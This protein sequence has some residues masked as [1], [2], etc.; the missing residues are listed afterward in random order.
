MTGTNSKAEARTPTEIRHLGY[1]R[2]STY[3]Q[4]LDTQLEQFRADGCVE[5]YY[6]KV[7]GARTDR[8]EL[9]KLLKALTPG[10]VVIVTRIDRLAR[11]I[12]DLFA[13]V[14]QIVDAGGQFRS[15]AEPWTDTATGTG[16]LTIAAL[17]RLIDV[18]R[19]LI[20][21]RMM[22]GR[23]RAKARGQRF[24]PP[25][26]SPTR[27]RRKPAFA[28]PKERRSRNWRRPMMSG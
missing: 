18:E 21:T 19:D 17:G 2:V 12:F 5:I 9:L 25:G 14:K 8:R 28:A 16:R 4:T 11:S 20:R 22:D 7:S 6:E 26:N 15:L 1:A 3:G 24:G 23:S 13:M 10:D 27:R